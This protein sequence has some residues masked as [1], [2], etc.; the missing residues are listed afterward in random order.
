VEGGFRFFFAPFL[1]F[2]FPFDTLKPVF[3]D[4]ASF[5]FRRTMMKCVVRF[6]CFSFVG[7]GF[8]DQDSG[9]LNGG[10]AV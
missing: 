2:C 5:F 9:C 8:Y 10:W 1:W 4:D 3:C 7:G 6:K